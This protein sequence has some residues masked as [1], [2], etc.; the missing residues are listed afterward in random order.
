MEGKD[1]AHAKGVDNHAHNDGTIIDVPIRMC[2][3]ISTD[4]PYQTTERMA[5]RLLMFK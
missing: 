3:S 2:L 5:T 1:I 4:I